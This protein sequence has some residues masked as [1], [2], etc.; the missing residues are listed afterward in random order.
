MF[1][2]LSDSDWEVYAE[3]DVGL[4]PWRLAKD[5]QERLSKLVRLLLKLGGK[6]VRLPPVPFVMP[7]LSK[8]RLFDGA[9]LMRG[10]WPH[11]CHG[12]TARIWGRGEGQLRMATG[13]ALGGDGTWHPHSWGL[14]P[15]PRS[16]RGRPC[17]HETTVIMEKYFGIVLGEAEALEG[18]VINF[19][20]LYGAWPMKLLAKRKDGRKLLA[21][22]GMSLP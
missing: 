16:R 18:W 12:N 14:G 6:A 5:E 7:L 4:I 3:Q 17:I 8:G 10:G 13:Y 22:H 20:R 1:K 19:L 11:H 2:Q 21:R 9:I 15:G